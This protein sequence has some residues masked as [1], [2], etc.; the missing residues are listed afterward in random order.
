MIQLELFGKLVPWCAPRLGR[1]KVYAPHSADKEK[2]QWQLRAQYRD[3]PI[4][5]DVHL[6]FT[7][8]FPIPKSTSGV[9]RRQMLAHLIRPGVK[10]DNTNLLKFYEDCLSGIVIGDDKS[11]TDHSMRKRYSEVT[12]VL[13]RVIPLSLFATPTAEFGCP[14]PILRRPSFTG[15]LI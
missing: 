1:G 8:F 5:G 13:I 6:D 10:P 9:R 15:E 3:P 11:A 12:R 7:F 14:A 4:E 2:A